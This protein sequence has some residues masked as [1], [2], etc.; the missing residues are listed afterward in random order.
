MFHQVSVPAP[1]NQHQHLLPVQLV[2]TPVTTT[3]TVALQVDMIVPVMKLMTVL[4][5]T[6]VEVSQSVSV[7]NK[8][9][10]YC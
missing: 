9:V 4:L 7:N 2:Q 10:V 1:V 6:S 3:V 8:V 5:H